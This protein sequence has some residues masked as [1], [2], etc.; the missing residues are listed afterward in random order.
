V[1]VSQNCRTSEGKC[2][3]SVDKELAG[4][5]REVNWEIP[6]VNSGLS[7]CYRNCVKLQDKTAVGNTCCDILL[8]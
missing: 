2:C 6:L 7:L 1:C 4:K 5:A 3:I 8:I